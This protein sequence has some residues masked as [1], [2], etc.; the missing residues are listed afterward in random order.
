MSTATEQQHG[1]AA[2][3]RS[4]TESETFDLAGQ[5]TATITTTM[6]AAFGSPF[7]LK[8]MIRITF[9]TGAGRQARQKY[10]AAAAKTVTTALQQCGYTEDRGASCVV[11]SAGCYKLQHDT[12]KNLK[13]IVVFPKIMTKNNGGGDDNNDEDES[14]VLLPKNSPVYKIAA[15]SMNVFPVMI[16]RECPSWSQKKT[17]LESIH[18]MQQMMNEIEQS[19]VHGKPLSTAEQDFYD[20]TAVQLDE[21]EGLVRRE[22]A[23]HIEEGKVTKYEKDALLEQNAARIQSLKQEGNQKALNKALE[24]KAL[25]ESMTTVQPPHA[26]KHHNLL[27]KLY[28]ELAPIQHLDSNSGRLLSLKET[29]ALNRKEELLEEIQ[30]LEASSRGWFEDDEIFELR[31]QASRQVFQQQYAAKLGSKKGAPAAS[32]S[33]KL[34]SSS[35]SSGGVNKWVT[36]GETGFQKGGGYSSGKKKKKKQGASLFQAMVV[37]SSSE[38]E[39][40]EETN[41]RSTTRRGLNEWMTAGDAEGQKGSGKLSNTKNKKSTEGGALFQAMM[42][43]SSDDEEDA[44]RKSSTNEA[45]NGPPLESSKKKKSKKNKKKKKSKAKEEDKYLESAVADARARTK[46]EE[47]IQKEASEQTMAKIVS[48]LQAYIFPFIVALLGLILG[49][50]NVGKNKNNKKQHSKKKR[51]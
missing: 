33:S 39:E 43:S 46:A 36:P 20:S 9:I 2:R 8:E 24:R 34:Q 5:S 11:E 22:I 42:D 23:L 4:C 30:Q 32:Y 41:S 16:Q 44:A 47:E 7:S 35:R 12:G 38:E 49:F 48:F 21:K 3:I 17:C 27:G 14:N 37:D 6:E 13:T 19:L 28:K 31:V 25:L 1:L 10:D 51:S 40:E 18:M 50:F 15:C 29:K 45:A 26:L